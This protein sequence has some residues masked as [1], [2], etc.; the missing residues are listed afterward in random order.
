MSL[1]GPDGLLGK[2][3]KMVFETGLEAEMSEQ[4]TRW[5]G[6]TAAIH[7]TAPGQNDHHRDR[8]H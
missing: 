2:L 3:T 4:P 5:F 1:V 8:A 6:V 7:A